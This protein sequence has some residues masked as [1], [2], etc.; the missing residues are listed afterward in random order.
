MPSPILDRQLT[1]EWGQCDPAGTVSNNPLLRAV[2]HQYLASVSIGPASIW[3]QYL[4]EVIARFGQQVLKEKLFKP[5]DAVGV[6][7]KF[8]LNGLN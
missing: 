3:R 7:V 1:V 6:A 8:E 5:I 4:P 2:R